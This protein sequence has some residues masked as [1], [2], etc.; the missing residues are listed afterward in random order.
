MIE[1]QDI[2]KVYP[3]GKRELVALNEINLE[4]EKGELVAIMG[5]SGSGKT[6]MLNL[7]GCL[8]TPTSG[9]YYLEDREVSRLSRNELAEIRGLKIGFIFQTFNL[10]PVLTAYEN[11]EFPLLLLDY[12]TRGRRERIMRALEEVGIKDQEKQKPDQMSGGQ[13]QR[14]AIARALVKDPEIIL[15]DEP[16]ANLDSA[17][18]ENMPLRA[19]S[20]LIMA[21]ISDF[22]PV[23]TS[24]LNGTTAIG[25]APS[26][27]S[28]I[29]IFNTALAVWLNTATIAIN[30]QRLISN[31]HSPKLQI[32]N[33]D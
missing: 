19:R 32:R 31:L 33:P 13:R 15:A 21:A 17:T 9:K 27:P 16:T 5:P 8:D 1:L 18:G 24:T 30:N 6:T 25:V 28:V 23:R 29:S 2:T 4:V 11:V 26:M 7:L 22:S 12:P 10:I 14:V 20:E 3:M